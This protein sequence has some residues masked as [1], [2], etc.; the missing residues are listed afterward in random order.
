MI[1]SLM[2]GVGEE[3]YN[4]DLFRKLVFCSELG[5]NIAEKSFYEIVANVGMK[6][7]FATEEQAVLFEKAAGQLSSERKVLMN[8]LRNASRQVKFESLLEK[9]FE[10]DFFLEG[11]FLNLNGRTLSDD[12][13]SFCR[14]VRAADDSMI[15]SVS[16]VN[17]EGDDLYLF[18]ENPKDL[19]MN[20][21]AEGFV[22]RA[23][24]FGEDYHKITGKMLFVYCPEPGYD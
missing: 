11:L 10:R 5:V 14:V 21:V 23:V 19:C 17:C 3:F 16:A 9:H 22:D 6:V 24:N 1:S 4:S 18:N 8:V 7:P 15:A 20:L 12:G 13:Y 2:Y